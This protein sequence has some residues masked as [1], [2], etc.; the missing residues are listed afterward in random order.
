VARRYSNLSPGHLPNGFTRILRWGVLDRLSGKR[1]RKP[2]GPAAPH[3]RADLSFLDSTHSTPRLTWIGHASFLASFG[4]RHLL[5]DPVFSNRIGAVVPRH[6]PPGLSPDQLPPLVAA[7][8]THCHYDHLD[9]ASIRALP[10]DVPIVVPLGVETLMRNWGR[11]RVVPLGR[12]ESIELG[13]IRVTLV[14]SRHWSRRGL[15]DTNATL[16]GGYV[17]ETEQATVYHAGDSAW[18]D[19]FATI[20]ERFP[21]LL[22]AMLPI[23]AYDPSWFM[24]QQHLNPEQAGEAFLALGARHLIPMHWGTFR[25]ADEP[26][27]EPIERLQRWWD[28]RHPAG[29]RL[30][31]P[32][33][34]ETISLETSS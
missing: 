16:W 25:L 10:S 21:D 7:L 13:D 33:V 3:A 22:A 6:C 29:K 32:A 8:V 23:G 28:A 27:V 2:S 19:G 18:F 30:H 14:P 12:W 31:C 26:L 34:G 11:Q 15:F 1:R 4:A 5:L 17:I 20:G 24:E 9:K